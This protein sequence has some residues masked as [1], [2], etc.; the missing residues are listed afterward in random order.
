MIRR[1]ALILACLLSLSARA[2]V[3][4]ETVATGLDHP[5]SMAFL[6]DGSMLVTERNG[7]LRMIRAG[8]LLPGPVA[9][10][11]DAYVA[12]QGGLFDVLADPDFATNQT[13][14]LS[15]AHGDAGDNA[16]R[17]VSARL[18]DDALEDVTTLFTTTPG[19]DTP[20]HYGGRMAFLPD[21]TLLLTT[22]EGFVYRE[23]AQR[24]DNHF[25][26]VIRIDTRGDVPAD[27]PYAN[28]PNKLGEIYSYGHRNPQGLV[29]IPD[30]GVVYL[31]EHGPR[32]GDELNRIEAGLNYGW[33]AITYGIDYTGARISPYTELPGMEQPLVYWVPSIAPSGMTY[34]DGSLFPEWQGDLFVSTLV[35]RSVRRLDL[36]NGEVRDQEILFTDIGER[37]RDVRAGPDGAL[38]LLTDSGDGSVIRVTPDE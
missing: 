36:E 22:G 9:G 16:T 2:D 21:G 33:P 29:V 38:Y 35:E 26:K 37:I 32:G 7:G 15:F 5:W 19:K 18:V 34:Y 10:V 4:Y 28:E 11:P 12:G 6:P 13:V 23:Q 25:G 17:V 1:F 3:V 14:Y 20:H 27:N 30:T 31:H 8:E 24:L